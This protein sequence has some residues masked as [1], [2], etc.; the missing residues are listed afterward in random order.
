MLVSVNVTNTKHKSRRTRMSDSLLVEDIN[1]FTYMDERGTVVIRENELTM[2]EA[3]HIA[4]NTEPTHRNVF[5]DAECVTM[6]DD[7]CVLEAYLKPP[8]RR[9][10]DTYYH[11]FVFEDELA[12]GVVLDV[13]KADVERGRR[14]VWTLQHLKLIR[15]AS[16]SASMELLPDGERSFDYEMF[17]DR[18]AQY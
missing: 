12:A 13:I 1:G 6:C 15:S 3:L 14:L 18:V 10:M 9:N 4:R 17:G 2:A 16:E 8:M 5:I 7:P 11:R